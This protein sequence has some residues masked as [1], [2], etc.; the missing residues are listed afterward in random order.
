MA[1][2][3]WVCTT[4]RCSVRAVEGQVQRH[5][6][7]GLQRSVEEVAVQVAHAH[8]LG[9]EGVVVEAARGGDH[10]VTGPDAQVAGG[11]DHQAVRPECLCVPDDLGPL[12]RQPHA[13]RSFQDRRDFWTTMR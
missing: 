5:L 3:E 4:A 13:S 1:A 12:L 7:R 10:Q 11:P 9:S 2:V 6:R 8:Q